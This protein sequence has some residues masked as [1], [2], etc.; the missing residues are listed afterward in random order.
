MDVEDSSSD[1]DVSSDEEEQ[2]RRKN[3]KNKKKKLDPIVSVQMVDIDAMRK[4]KNFYDSDVEIQTCR[5]RKKMETFRHKC[6]ISWWFM[7][8]LLQLHRL[9]YFHDDR[10]M[11]KLHDMMLKAQDYLSLFRYVAFYYVKDMIAW[12][13]A[14]DGSLPF[15]VVEIAPTTAVNN[16][17][18]NSA[19]SPD[20]M[21]AFYAVRR[22][23]HFEQELIYECADE[24]I[25]KRCDFYVY[26]TGAVFVPSGRTFGIT[27]TTVCPVSAFS[28]LIDDKNEIIEA[29]VCLGDANFMATHPEGF[30]YSKPL[31]D[32]SPENVPEQTRYMEN[33]MPSAAFATSMY[34]ANLSA[35]LANSYVNR[36]RDTARCMT[37]QSQ[38]RA[39][40]RQMYML[41]GGGG[42]GRQVGEDGQEVI[43]T[44]YHERQ[45]EF[46]RPSVKETLEHLPSY[47]EVS[48]GPPPASLMNPQLL[49]AQY[50]DKVAQLMN[51]PYLLFKPQRAGGTDSK[52]HGVA[53][54]NGNR[55]NAQKQL[56]DAVCEQQQTFQYIFEELYERTFARMDRLLFDQLPEQYRA[57]TD[58]ISA[59]MLFDNQITKSDEAIHGLLP[60]YEAGIV[61]KD[62]LRKLL[63]RNFGLLEEDEQRKRDD[64]DPA[65][66]DR[67]KNKEREKRASDDN[68]DD[69]DSDKETKSKKSVNNRRRN[70]ERAKRDDDEDDDSDSET[71]TKK[72]GNKQD[73]KEK[74][75][76]DDDEEE[77]EDEIRVDKKKTKG[78]KKKED[79]KEDAGKKKRKASEID[80]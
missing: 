71:K 64:E 65:G 78:K 30:L 7:N 2:K 67:R 57:L 44:L 58:H 37:S 51:F 26:D 52:A 59:R 19:A 10:Y 79:E 23:G 77:E 6:T 63:V 48:R 13:L 39:A 16:N 28:E 27:R 34:R 12:V 36:F 9:P 62:D 4:L 55:E 3:T 1:D 72:T 66:N 49:R 40:L 46:A 5:H 73:D 61:S 8:D 38:D 70:K 31:P 29:Q 20:S 22:N 33:D 25:N 75:E 56:D 15:G 47:T 50:V 11:R 54:S 24:T 42:G 68:E 14:D 18:N 21:G 35:S 80:K 41:H 32:T 45:A 53:V 60:F 69:D 76:E 74:K 17:S 43:P